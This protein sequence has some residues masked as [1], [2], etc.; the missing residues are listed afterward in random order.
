MGGKSTGAAEKLPDNNKRLALLEAGVSA[1][2]MALTA[3]GVKIEEGADVFGIAVSTL[4]AEKKAH[5]EAIEQISAMGAKVDQLEKA[6]EEINRLGDY[7]LAN[8]NDAIDG[9]AVDTVIKL[10]SASPAEAAAADTDAGDQAAELER[11]R[12]RVA[13]LENENAELQTDVEDAINERNTLRNKLSGE[14]QSSAAA[15]VEEEAAPVV[16]A[17]VRERPDSARDVGPSFGSLTADEIQAAIDAG[18]AFEIA[19]SNG[20]YEIVEFGPI[21]IAGSDLHRFAT[22][23]FAVAP[24]LHIKG[25]VLTEDI[26]GAGLLMEGVQV[27]YCSFDPAVR[28]EPGQERAFNRALIFG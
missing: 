24:T 18:G 21:T 20:E 28:I 14:G 5:S 7:L 17:I 19:F 25:A 22:N 4:K 10:L 13:E 16:P 12:V 3:N 1:L 15:V 27:G 9:S 2:A 6:G 23:Q 26:D 8:H 11:L